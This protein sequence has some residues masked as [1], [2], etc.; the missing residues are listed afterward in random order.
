MKFAFV[1]I[2]ITFVVLVNARTVS[3]GNKNTLRKEV[4][5]K[6][7]SKFLVRAGAE[8]IGFLFGSIQS[9]Q[10]C[11]KPCLDRVNATMQEKYHSVKSQTFCRGLFLFSSFKIVF[12]IS[13]FSCLFF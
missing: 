4:Q 10:T 12:V 7:M 11:S 9:N 13:Y 5:I 8:N 6:P 1:K 3:I 2:F